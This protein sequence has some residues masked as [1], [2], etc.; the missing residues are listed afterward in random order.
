MSRSVGETTGPD[1]GWEWGPPRYP[2]TRE[3][4][5]RE[6]GASGTASR[7]NHFEGG[8]IY[9]TADTGARVTWGLIRSAWWALGADFSAL[10]FPTGDERALPDG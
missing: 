3:W 2:T 1:G 5:S 6:S 7:G 9:W 4:S 8:T 10:G